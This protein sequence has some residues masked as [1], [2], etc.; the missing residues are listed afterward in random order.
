MPSGRDA[1]ADV[2]GKTGDTPE[3]GATTGSSGNWED[4]EAQGAV[5]WPVAGKRV[6]NNV[7][8]GVGS[9]WSGSPDDNWGPEYADILLFDTTRFDPVH[10]Y[11]YIGGCVRLVRDVS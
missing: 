8:Y 5:F 1:R 3:V 4:M 11:R 10:D 7:D 9:Y 2:A 6:G